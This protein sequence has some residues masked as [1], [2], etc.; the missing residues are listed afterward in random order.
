MV[1]GEILQSWTNLE[2]SGNY[3]MTKDIEYTKHNPF[4]GNR[5]ASTFG[6]LKG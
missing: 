2:T 4:D 5:S 6:G 3:Y 1:Y